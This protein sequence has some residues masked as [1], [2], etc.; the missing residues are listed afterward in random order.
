M[1]NAA[2]QE[3]VEL[4]WH[5]EESCALYGPA[6]DAAEQDFAAAGAVCWCLLLLAT[7]REQSALEAFQLLPDWACLACWGPSLFPVFAARS[8]R[9]QPQHPACCPAAG[10]CLL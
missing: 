8:K 4:S 5:L 7:Y 9:L 10:R 6:A 3:R 1:V 2:S